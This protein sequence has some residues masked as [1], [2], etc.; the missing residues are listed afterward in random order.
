MPFVEY[1]VEENS[2][3]TDGQIQSRAEVCSGNDSGRCIRVLQWGSLIKK[4]G[5]T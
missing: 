4:D 1:S 3:A 2:D 5:V